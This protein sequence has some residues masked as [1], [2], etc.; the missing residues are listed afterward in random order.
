MPSL[1]PAPHSL[2]HDINK[3]SF[4]SLCFSFLILHNDKDHPHG[5]SRVVIENCILSVWISQF[6]WVHFF[7]FKT[8]IKQRWRK[9]GSEAKWSVWDVCLGWH[10]RENGMCASGQRD[11]GPSRRPQATCGQERHRFTPTP[12]G[13]KAASWNPTPFLRQI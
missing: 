10:E 11:A 12:E 4:E 13:L 7:F 2:L 1:K 6:E 5:V 8:E 3:Q 9:V